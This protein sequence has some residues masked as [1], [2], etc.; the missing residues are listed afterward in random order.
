MFDLQYLHQHCVLR[1]CKF[2]PKRN[3]ANRENLS[4]IAPILTHCGY[5]L[6]MSIQ[7]ERI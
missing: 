1:E 7:A 2:L 4:E 6:D 3:V 5:G